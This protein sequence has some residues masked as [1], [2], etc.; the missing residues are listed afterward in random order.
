[1]S[2]ISKWLCIAVC[3]LS[4]AGVAD[5]R[6]EF[7]GA[8]PAPGFDQPPNRVHTGRYLN[9]VYGYSVVI[10][11]ALS[12]YSSARRRPRARLRHRAVVDAARVPE[13]RCRL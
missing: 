8:V 6:G 1:M 5:A 2:E 7:C 4:V 12:A 11:A 13:R 9:P 3:V 10:P